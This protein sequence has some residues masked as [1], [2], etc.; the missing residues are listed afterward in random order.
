K[1]EH[2]GPLFLYPFFCNY[3]ASEYPH[4]PSN[5][6]RNPPPI[7]IPPRSG[8]H[9]LVWPLWLRL[10]VLGIY[11]Y[12]ASKKVWGVLGNFDYICTAI[13]DFCARWSPNVGLSHWNTVYYS[14]ETVL[15]TL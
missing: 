2:A 15:I 1:S 5:P 13:R 7:A 11:C 6:H 10:S 3:S 9:L 8:I 4:P 14:K 12:K